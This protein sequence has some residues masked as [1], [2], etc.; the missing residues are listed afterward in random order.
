MPIYRIRFS[1]DYTIREGFDRYVEAANRE[2][3]AEIADGFAA[4]C[5]SDCPDDCSEIGGGEAG[6]FEV[7]S[8]ALVATKPQGEELSPGTEMSEAARM[9]Q[10][11]ARLD[12]FTPGWREIIYDNGQRMFREDGM[13]L[14]DQG[15]RSV[16]DDI[17][18]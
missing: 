13:M 14:D 12:K 18:E 10:K 2:E 9:A 15:N 17:D 1:R 16:F 11:R 7:D 5:D 3:A 6:E 4:F 8:V